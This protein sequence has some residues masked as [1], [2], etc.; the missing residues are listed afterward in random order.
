MKDHE[1]PEEYLRM[2]THLR[3]CG[4]WTDRDEPW[5]TLLEAV[6]RVGVD[7]VVRV[8][9]MAEDS[10]EKVT[11]QVQRKSGGG[12]T[13]EFIR[14]EKIAGLILDGGSLGAFFGDLLNL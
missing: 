4:D 9:R 2:Q 11:I 5:P 13:V 7:E 14:P 3:W 10:I 1:S 12:Q 6:D 8:L